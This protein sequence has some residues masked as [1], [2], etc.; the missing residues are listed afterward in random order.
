MQAN[1][2]NVGGS[3]RPDISTDMYICSHA[4]A[5]EPR[6]F[7]DMIK[8]ILLYV[9]EVGLCCLK[10]WRRGK[11]AVFLEAIHTYKENV[12]QAADSAEGRD[13]CFYDRQRL[14]G[15]HDESSKESIAWDTLSVGTTRDTQNDIIY[16]NSSVMF[17]YAYEHIRRNTETYLYL[18]I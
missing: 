13:E 4:N 17:V 6:N 11:A 1:F 2:E 8:T 16:I 3:G 7:L 18:K 15:H 5:S 9:K 12:H 10:P 14:I